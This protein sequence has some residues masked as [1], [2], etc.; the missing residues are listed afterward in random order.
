MR[1]LVNFVLVFPSK[2]VSF[3]RFSLYLTAEFSPFFYVWSLGDISLSLRSLLPW[4]PSARCHGNRTLEDG[5]ALIRSIFIC[6]LIVIFALLV[7][8]TCLLG[9]DFL[10]LHYV[11]STFFSTR[12]VGDTS[13]SLPSLAAMVTKR[14]GVWW[15]RY[16]RS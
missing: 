14:F 13:L 10:C 16:V 15:C 9:A 8:K 3:E 1:F 6:I 2:L 4:Q 7:S 12:S 11:I 5:A